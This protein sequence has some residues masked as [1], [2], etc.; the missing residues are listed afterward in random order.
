MSPGNQQEFIKIEPQAGLSGDHAPGSGDIHIA[1]EPEARFYR[2]ELDWLRFAAFSAVFLHHAFPA[3]EVEQ[4]VTGIRFLLETLVVATIETSRYGVDLFF[5]LSAF[6][7][8]ELLLLEKERTGRVHVPAFYVRRILRIWPLYITFV[9]V[10][11]SLELMFRDNPPLFY[12]ALLGFSGNWF[13]VFHEAGFLSYCL[14]LWSLCVEEQFYIVWPNLVSRAKVSHFVK[15]MVGLLVFTCLYRFLYVYGPP[16]NS[17]SVWIN[18][19]TRLDPFALGGLLAIFLH[20][21]GF[22]LPNWGRLIVLMAGIGTF[23]FLGTFPDAAATGIPTIWSF[24]LS[25]FASVLCVASFVATSPLQSVAAW[26]RILSYLGK[27][28]YGAYVFHYGMVFIVS[29]WMVEEPVTKPLGILFWIYRALIAYP[30]TILLAVLS[31]ELLE[32]RFLKLKRRFTFV[33]SRPA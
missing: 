21:R 2:P 5:A 23:I 14:P 31:Y 4:G 33:E 1:R 19:L 10:V 26:A 8:T 13:I 6:L 24:P 32:K 22:V 28:S 15:I 7:I 18:T 11:G 16:R 12:L 3:A 9:L 17:Q 25:A 20:N 30:L 27:I 29:S